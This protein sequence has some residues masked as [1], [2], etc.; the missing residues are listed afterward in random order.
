MYCCKKI[1]GIVV[2]ILIII[3]VGFFGFAKDYKRGHKVSESIETFVHRSISTYENSANLE[4]YLAL[5]NDSDGIF[6]NKFTYLFV[7]DSVSEIEIGNAGFPEIVG[8]NTRDFLDSN[9]EN[10]GDVILN[11]ATEEG[12]WIQYRWFNPENKTK[13]VTKYAYVVKVG[14][15]IF[16]AGY[17]KKGIRGSKGGYD[18]ENNDYEGKSGRDY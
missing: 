2:I 18:K 13:E 10:I 17:D 11:G 15:L 12:A 8:M 5:V 14:D 3:A 9:G 6:K 1:I 7:T 4:D 16:G